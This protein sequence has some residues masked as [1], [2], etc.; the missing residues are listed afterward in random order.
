[1]RLVIHTQ[2]LARV[3]GRRDKAES[4]GD[5]GKKEKEKEGEKGVLLA[6]KGDSLVC[7]VV[8]KRHDRPQ[9]FLLQYRI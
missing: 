4:K 1:M 8:A 9:R 5:E 7:S 3:H 6:T 2:I